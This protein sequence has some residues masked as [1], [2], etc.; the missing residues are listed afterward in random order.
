LITLLLFVG[1]ALTVSALCSL[2][3]AAL[4]ASR[5]PLLAESRDLGSVGAGKLFEL[6]RARLDDSISAILILNTLANT[7]G[8]TLAGAQ[9]TVVFGDVWVGV[10]SGVL[11]FLIL[12]VAEII[13]KTLGA[14]Y[15]HSLTPFVGWTLWALTRAMA[16]VL[17]LSGVLTRFLTQNTRVGYSRGE[18]AAVIDAA[19]SDGAI[20]F[21]ESQM[22]G[23]LLRL[24]EVQVEDVMTP[25]TVAFMMPCNATVAELLTKR[26]ALIFSRIPL[27]R[28][29]PDNVIGY[30]RLTDVLRSV[31]ENGNRE[32]ALDGFL[33]EIS[34][35]PELATVGSALRQFLE[36]REQ[37][38]MVTDEHG[39]IAGLVSM[40]DLTETVLGVEIVDESDAHVDLRQAAIRLRDR[41][42]ERLRQ[43]RQLPVEA[44]EAEEARR[45]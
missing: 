22:L 15:V 33:R 21:D 4:L 10:F 16:P 39:G 7:L 26:E 37:V 30:L 19:T 6:K 27:Y 20:S 11:T 43:R 40:E 36:R 23:S 25:R 38:A 8:A 17:S 28:D 1:F 45:P 41:R 31:A 44:N 3:E 42:L 32:L 13:P 35:V 12:V 34:F 14:V 29:Q 5:M 2:L 24:N 18:L 9:A